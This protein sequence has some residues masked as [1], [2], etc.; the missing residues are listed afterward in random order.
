MERKMKRTNILLTSA[1]CVL[2]IYA[3]TATTATTANANAT[4]TENVEITETE[5]IY[6]LST[7][8]TSIDTSTDTVTVEDYNGN[9]WSFYGIEDWQN[10]DRCSLIM[11]TN[12]TPSIYDDIIVSQK[13]DG[14]SEIH[15]PDNW[16]M[17]YCESSVTITDW[18]ISENGNEIA[19]QLSDGVE[20]YAEK[21]NAN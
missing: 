8:V 6:A 4:E 9:L 21:Q 19:F 15:D 14:Q 1:L 7:V 20:L 16:A 17:D 13:Y 10:G 18:N 5:N 3:T 11:S 2:S 12:N